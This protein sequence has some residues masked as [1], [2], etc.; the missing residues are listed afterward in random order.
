MAGRR[1]SFSSSPKRRFS[2]TKD[3]LP[4]FTEDD[5]RNQQDDPDKIQEIRDDRQLFF[6]IQ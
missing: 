6:D 1:R 2:T 3:F 4:T 5:P